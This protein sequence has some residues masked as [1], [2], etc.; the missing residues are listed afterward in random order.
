MKLE[1]PPYGETATC[2]ARLAP[3][4]VG[5]GLDVG[6]GGTPITKSAICLDRPEKHGGRAKFE[7]EPW[8]T[9]LV[10]D[11][12]NLWWFND[13]VLDFVFCVCPGMPITTK[14][15][16]INVENVVVGD[17]VLNVNGDWA[18]VGS[19]SARRFTGEIYN[20]K[21]HRMFLPLKIT[22]NHRALVNRNGVEMFVRA[23]EITYDDW[24]I[25]PATS[26]NDDLGKLAVADSLPEN[27]KDYEKV[28]SMSGKPLDLV[29]EKTGLHRSTVWQWRT[30]RRTP[31]D[32]YVVN[33]GWVTSSIKTVPVKNSIIV[34]DKLCR[35]IGYYASDGCA[36][37]G[38]LSFYFNEG[39]IK[40][41]DDAIRLI[42]DIFGVYPVSEAFVKRGKMFR[43]RYCSK[44]LCLIFKKFAGSPN[45]KF[46]ADWI[47]RLPPEKQRG[48]IGG[49]FAGDGTIEK[50]GKVATYTSSNFSLIM[51]VRDLLMRQ[52][53]QV[54]LGKVD[55]SKYN[56]AIRG[57]KIKPS[58]RYFV[59][60]F[61]KAVDSV[62]RWSGK[63]FKKTNRGR[64]SV[65]KTQNVSVLAHG[66]FYIKPKKISREPY[67]G[68]VYDL[69]IS[70]PL[71]E[72]KC[73]VSRPSDSW[74]TFT[75][76][77]IAVHNSSH[78]LEDFDD[79]SAV[80]REWFRVLRPGGKLVLFLPDQA[81]YVAYCL[82]NHALPNQAHKHA[83]FGLDFIKARLPEGG[84]I[85]HELFPVDGNPYSFDLVYEKSLCLNS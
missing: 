63:K 31:S 48:L 15:G 54:T 65:L 25:S 84:R 29:A 32:C 69:T 44:L 50:N 49:L 1:L 67:D 52:G 80:L 57:R 68:L 22:G 62:S 30:S 76:C 75:C 14:R 53:I 3:F 45:D 4:C 23:D 2:R 6:F 38:Q 33:N 47:M 17:E 16:Q 72:S 26:Q 9:H 13:N 85:I 34:S 51:Q 20:I 82:A 59:S 10:G 73:I 61:G 39:E 74:R 81:T 11:A 27:K 46:I 24:L 83:E 41:R 70:K 66:S 35:L 78:V 64:N 58:I 37:G 28:M 18:K 71:V 43:V 19:I 77:G 8:P 56:A 55:T 21:P 7:D 42:R 60:V 40:F 79:T 36:S 5:N 12:A